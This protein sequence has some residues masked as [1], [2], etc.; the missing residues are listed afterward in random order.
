MLNLLNL[1]ATLG[2][3]QGVSMAL[4]NRLEIFRRQMFEGEVFR[5]H[6]AHSEFRENVYILREKI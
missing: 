6:T 4:G 1:I 3:F 5:L 2:M